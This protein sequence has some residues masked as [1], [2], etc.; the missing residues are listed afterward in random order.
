MFGYLKDA[1]SEE[2]WLL[3]CKF[4]GYALQNKLAFADIGEEEAEIILCPHCGADNKEA[5]LLAEDAVD[6]ADLQSIKTLR[7]W[8][9]GGEPSFRRTNS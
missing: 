1:E 9:P 7:T 4:M 6:I 2:D 8:N 3:H 5:T